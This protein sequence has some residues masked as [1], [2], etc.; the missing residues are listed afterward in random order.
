[1][2][3]FRRVDAT[4][5]KAIQQPVTSRSTRRDG[6][7]EAVDDEIQPLKSEH[8]VSERCELDHAIYAVSVC[9]AGSWSFFVGV[10]RLG[11][12]GLQ[13]DPIAV[14]DAK[15]PE[16]AADLIDRGIMLAGGGAL[17]RGLDKLLTEETGLPVFVA[18]DPLK[19]VA[20]GTGIVLQEIDIMNKA[21][22]IASSYRRR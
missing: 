13:L 12:D 22:Q 10:P 9:V 1:M 11:R 7:I 20:N 19:A 16:L 15:P 3:V 8:P 14:L 4:L 6:G 2:L 17:L 21:F 18:D 5:D